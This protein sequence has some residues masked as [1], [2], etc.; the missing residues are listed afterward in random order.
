MLLNRVDLLLEDEDGGMSTRRSIEESAEVESLT[1]SLIDGLYKQIKTAE[2][3]DTGIKKK[4]P[5]N[6]VGAKKQV[7]TFEKNKRPTTAKKRN[8]STKSR[9]FD[10]E[11]AH[12][13]ASFR[14]APD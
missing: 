5:T 7:I 3:K 6:F 2:K 4:K 10:Y 1:A 13:T 9:L 8:T 14:A 12:K 11:R